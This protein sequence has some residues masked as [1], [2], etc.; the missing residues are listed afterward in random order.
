MP[1]MVVSGGARDNHQATTAEGAFFIC[2]LRFPGCV[3]LLTKTYSFELPFMV[4][5]EVQ[6]WTMCN[7]LAPLSLKLAVV[8]T[9]LQLVWET[10][11]S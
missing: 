10:P 4:N 7:F 11:I 3:S 1:Y 2:I 5:D 6:L 9:E 8:F